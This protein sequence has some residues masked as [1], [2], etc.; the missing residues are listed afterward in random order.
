MYHL[1]FIEPFYTA[2]PSAAAFEMEELILPS[3]I[4]I[5]KILSKPT[6]ISLFRSFIS[7]SRCWWCH[8]VCHLL[9][10]NY[11]EFSA[12]IS[13]VTLTPASRKGV[14]PSFDFS[15]PPAS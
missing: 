4:Q 1:L 12:T 10:F 13:F 14:K 6:V 9:F 11:P 5:V 8:L 7:R 3:L 2:D 15:P